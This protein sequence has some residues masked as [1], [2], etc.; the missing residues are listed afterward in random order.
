MT[1]DVKDYFLIPPT[2]AINCPGATTSKHKAVECDAPIYT[3]ADPTFMDEREQSFDVDEPY[4]KGIHSASSMEITEHWATPIGEDTIEIGEDLRKSLIEVIAKDGSNIF[5]YPDNDPNADAIRE[6]EVIS[7]KIIRDFI[8]EAYEIE[9][10]NSF[11]IEARSFGNQQSYGTRTYPHYHH[12]F[13]GVLIYYLTAGN[14][15]GLDDNNKI[16]YLSDDQKKEELS[17]R[18]SHDFAHGQV[19]DGSGNLILNDPRPAINYPYCNKAIAWSPVTGTLLLHPACIWHESNTF[20]GG[21]VRVSIVINY[22]I[23][24]VSNAGNVKPL[25]TIYDEDN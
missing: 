16:Y 15:F 9:D 21:G 23:L 13:D 8:T 10:I 11:D 3:T 5:I 14:E 17:P 19:L 1:S 2:G 24:T 18:P 6:F 25:A 12:G 20:T 4:A 22:R 7:N